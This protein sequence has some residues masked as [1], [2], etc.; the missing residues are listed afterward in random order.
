[1]MTERC[2]IILEGSYLEHTIDVGG[3]HHKKELKAGDVRF[4]FKQWGDWAP[5]HELRCNEPGIAGKPWHNFD[6]DTSVCRI[7]K[8]AAGRLLDGLTHDGYPGSNFTK[9]GQ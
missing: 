1:M 9:A 2:S 5:V 8:K 4:L 3:I 6:P 7:C